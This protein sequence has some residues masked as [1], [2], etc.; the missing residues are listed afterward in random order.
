MMEGRNEDDSDVLNP[1][2]SFNFVTHLG[3]KYGS[4]GKKESSGFLILDPSAFDLDLIIAGSID[5]AFLSMMV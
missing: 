3:N 1:Y 4:N 5:L 2:S